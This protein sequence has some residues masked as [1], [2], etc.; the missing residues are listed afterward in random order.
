MADPQAVDKPDFLVAVKRLSMTVETSWGSV[1]VETLCLLDAVRYGKAKQKY[2]DAKTDWEKIES[3]GDMVALVVGKNMPELI[4][5]PVILTALALTNPPLP[6]VAWLES[7]EDNRPKEDIVLV[8][9]TDYEG[10]EIAWFVSVL[11][12][13]FGWSHK[14]IL[15]DMTYAE[16]CC[17]V[18]EALIA[19]HDDREYAYMLA[20]VGF[21]KRG[22][23]TV[24][25]PFPDLPWRTKRPVRQVMPTMKVPKKYQPDG[26]VIDL[27]NPEVVKNLMGGLSDDQKASS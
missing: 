14:S 1:T 8:D 7:P 15:Y 17:Y 16:A 18:Q 2:Y 21:V 13:R 3:L 20:D 26:V 25:E 12:S 9:S 11:A 27:T 6:K 4:D 10:R 24:K 19:E 5:L 23:E 22:D